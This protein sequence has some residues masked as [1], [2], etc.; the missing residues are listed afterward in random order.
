MTHIVCFHLYNDFSGSPIV[1]R[2]V[3]DGLL[4]HGYQVDLVTSDGG[5]LDT[6]QARERF[7]KHSYTYRFS[8]NP[9]A[10]MLRYMAVQCYTFCLALRWAFR[11]DV[12][13]YINTLLPVGPALAGRLMGKR[14]VYHYHENAHVKG[15]FYQSLAWMMQR[16]AHEIICVSHYQ[17]AS[18]AAGSKVRVVPNALPKDFV[19]RMTPDAEKAFNLKTILMIAS[20]KAYKGTREFVELAVRMPE[21]RFILVL[22]E[23][24]ENINSFLKSIHGK[25]TKGANLKIYPRQSDTTPF[26]MKV[27]IVLNLSDKEKV[28]ETFGMTVLEAMTAGLPVIV[29]TV[30]GVAELV[31][32]G[33]NGYKIDAK[34]LELIEKR[35][36]EMLSDKQNYI[37]MANN[38]LKKARLFC[39]KN[40]ISAIE[41]LLQNGIR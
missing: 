9:I 39:A 32:N 12:V 17:A 18:L 23:T 11:K 29:P 33:K 15:V 21:Y 8:P 34:D 1:L 35:I 6:L 30:G 14:V 26:Y 16:L 5:V 24:Q 38:A 41:T 27:S 7:R 4:Q 28:I 13:F 2:M 25:T 37:G 22:N 3:L 40:M 10:T 20:L 19:E 31:E 36:H